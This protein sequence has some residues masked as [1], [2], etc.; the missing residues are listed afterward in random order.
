MSEFPT[1]FVVTVEGNHSDDD[2]TGVTKRITST[3]AEYRIVGPLADALR[4][5]DDNLDSAFQRAYGEALNIRAEV[6]FEF[7]NAP[8]GDVDM[9]TYEAVR[10]MA[11]EIA[12]LRGENDINRAHA[13]EHYEWLVKER[14]QTARLRKENEDLRKALKPFADMCGEIESCVA[15]YPADHPASNPEKWPDLL[16]A[17]SA[18]EGEK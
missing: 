17:R 8:A 9:E 4:R 12:R 7:L 16:R 13:V 5:H 18:Y 15:D 14:E 10:A 6:P 11:Q 1:M 3:G 2:Y